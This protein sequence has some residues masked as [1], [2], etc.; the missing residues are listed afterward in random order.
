MSL[1]QKIYL[2][3]LKK[4]LKNNNENPKQGLD[5]I[6][7]GQRPIVFLH[8]KENNEHNNQTKIWEKMKWNLRWWGDKRRLPPITSNMKSITRAKQ[9]PAPFGKSFIILSMIIDVAL[10]RYI[11]IYHQKGMR[12]SEELGFVF[13]GWRWWMKK[14]IEKC[15]DI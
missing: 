5:L 14:K 12:N 2:P 3:T 8:I 13:C 9:L 6:G 11:Y 1:Q 10:D 4:K 15:I 7:P